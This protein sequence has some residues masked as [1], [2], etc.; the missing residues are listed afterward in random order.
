MRYLRIIDGN[1]IEYP[2][3]VD[4]IKRANP[5]VSFPREWSAELLAEHNVFQV[6]KTPQPEGTE[7]HMVVE[8]APRLENGTWRQ[9]W[10]MVPRPAPPVPESI[11]RRQCA[12]QLLALQIISPAEALAMAKYGDMP[13][14]ILAVLDQAMASGSMTQEQRTLAEI[15]FAATNYY[16][17]NQLL[18][19]MGMESD[20]LDGFFIGAA[21][22]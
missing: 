18:G 16:R 4:N 2:Y 20:Q 19:M 8:A 15:D 11:T 22:I 6:E 21:Q 14:A 10:D 5:N 9:Q 13:A 17:S 3:D 1:E 12:L 7:T